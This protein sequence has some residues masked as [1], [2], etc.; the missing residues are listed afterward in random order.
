MPKINLNQAKKFLENITTKNKVAII[1][2]ND[3][4]GFT[5]GILFHNFLKN[6]KINHSNFIFTRN[7]SSFKNYNLKKFDTIIIADLAPS[8]IQEDLQLIKH[9]KTFYTDHHPKNKEIPKQ[10]LEYRTKSEISSA[11]TTYNL[12]GGNEFMEAM[13][14]STDAGSQQK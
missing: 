1:H 11:K 6:K 3:A 2:D 9:K 14:N 5:A 7:K 8:T 12:T 10:I 4:D 13:A